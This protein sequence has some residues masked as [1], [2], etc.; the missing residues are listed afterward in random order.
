LELAVLRGTRPPAGTGG[1]L[2]EFNR[3]REELAKLWRS[4]VSA[5]HAA[6]PRARLKA[7]DLD[8]IPALIDALRQA[9]AQIESL[10]S[11]KPFDF[12]E[13]AHRH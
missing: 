5:L 2:R 13:L 9:L 3:F 7:E 4:E 1:L 10:G 6:E 12:A 11:S 8:H